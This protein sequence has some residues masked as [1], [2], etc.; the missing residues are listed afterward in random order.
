MKLMRQRARFQRIASLG[1]VALL[2][3]SCNRD[4]ILTVTDPDIIN[5]ADLNSA[6]AAEALRVGA[7][8]RLNDMTA[9]FNSSIG[10]GSLAE[11][12][13]FYSG[14]LADEWRSTDTFV[15]RDELDSRTQTP[16]NTAVRSAATELARLRVQAML[17]VPVLRQFK[18]ANVSD[19]GQMFWI[20]GFGELS[21][22][23]NFC[24]GFPVP[25]LDNVS[26][27]TVLPLGTPE[28][29]VDTY[30]RALKSFDSA[31]VNTAAGQ[32]RGDTV[33]WLSALEKGRVLLDLGSYAA[34]GT[35]VTAA[36]IP[37]DFRF[38]MFYSVSSPGPSNQIWSLNNSAGRWMVANNEGPL[39]FNPASANDPRVP[40]CINTTGTG[41]GA[42][43]RN[44]DTPVS[45]NNRTASFDNNFPAGTFLQQLVWPNPDADV[46]IATGT[47]ARLIEAE[48]A[49]RSGDVATFLQKLNFLR[50]NYTTFKQPTDPCPATGTNV[51]GCP[52]IPAGG[53]LL[54]PLTDPGTQTARE[55]L[56]FR[57]RG[58]WLWSTA[59]RLA[60]LRRLV[61]P[62]AQ[63][64]FGRAETSIFPNGTYYKGGLYGTDKFLIVP[65]SEAN[66]PSAPS[67]AC[68][69]FNP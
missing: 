17:A 63:G 32:P 43:C 36:N 64:G 10:G 38:T 51:A 42:V 56:L 50:A 26:P 29:N 13:Y 40:I 44:F 68:A 47:E 59:H 48:A 37:N 31:I 24:N 2:A 58:F 67:G 60:D 39:G 5:P 52:T 65:A 14:A 11:S 53:N 41:A 6:E 30:A 22:A 18:P 4:K 69:D 16:T 21:I 19:V 7:L 28:N 12:I 25:D 35:T 46:A 15:Q 1:L 57:E 49:L 23:E 8:S 61:R 33:K 54:P 27:T 62:T 66:N 34:A 9:G 45:S 20:R 55:D 3:A